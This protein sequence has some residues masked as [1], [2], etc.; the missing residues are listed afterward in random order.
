MREDLAGEAQQEASKC[1][2][3]RK[4]RTIEV[5][6]LQTRELAWELE[7]QLAKWERQRGKAAARFLLK[8]LSSL[9]A[10]CLLVCQAGKLASLRACALAMLACL[11]LPPD[12]NLRSEF[13]SSVLFS[14]F[15]E[16]GGHSGLCG[17]SFFPRLD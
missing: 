5:R 4:G 2:K 1:T 11:P 7:N 9:V 8:F 15:V 13:E 3:P 12:L 17:C 10:S 14:L 6:K 16:G